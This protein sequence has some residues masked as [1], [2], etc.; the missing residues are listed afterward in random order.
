M[1]CLVPSIAGL[2]VNWVMK[3]VPDRFFPIL[4]DEDPS[5]VVAANI[6]YQTLRD[7]KKRI[8]INIAQMG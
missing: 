3:C 4:G 1:L 2:F 8:D 7:R 6:D 5:E